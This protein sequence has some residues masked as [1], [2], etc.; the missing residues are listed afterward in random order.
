MT[1]HTP[2]KGDRVRI[3]RDETLYPSKGVWP[4]Y[5]GRI[6]TVV[7]VNRARTIKVRDGSGTKTVKITAEYGVSF[8]KR[9]SVDSWFQV[10][11]LTVLA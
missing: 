1:T 4:Q 2:R 3:E 10:Y 9:T 7:T 11:E 8:T 5:K 6:G